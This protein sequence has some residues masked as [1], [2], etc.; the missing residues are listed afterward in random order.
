MK[1]EALFQQQVVDLATRFGWR[2]AHVGDSRKVV[3]R[4]DRY[5]AVPDPDCAG[6]PDLILVHPLRRRTIFAELKS[7]TGRLAAKQ[8]EWLAVLTE[9]GQETAVWR[10][11]DLDVIVETLSRR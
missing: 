7:K 9:A 3:R 11:G 4:G 1:P 6:L 10:P 2:V 5:I 8:K